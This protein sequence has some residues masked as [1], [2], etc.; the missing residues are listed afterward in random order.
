M[1]R[2]IYKAKRNKR[3]VPHEEPVQIPSEFKWTRECS[4]EAA[5]KSRVCLETDR[6]SIIRHLEV[7][8]MW[9]LQLSSDNRKIILNTLDLY[10]PK[11]ITNLIAYYAFDLLFV[12]LVNKLDDY[13]LKR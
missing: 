5:R 4:I 1:N 9:T 13:I 3:L 12:P 7:Y 8:S 2:K 10:V 6:A 11:E